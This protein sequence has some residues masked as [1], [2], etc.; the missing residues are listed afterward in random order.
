[1]K[2]KKEKIRYDGER[3]LLVLPYVAATSAAL[4]YTICRDHVWICTAVMSVFACAVYMLVYHF[5]KKPVGAAVLTLCMTALCFSA[6]LMTGTFYAENGFMDFLFTASSFFEPKFAAAAIVVFSVVIGFMCCYFSVIMPRICYLMLVSFIPL[7]LS[8]RTSG[9]TPVA[10]SA[11]MFGTFILAVLG[12]AKACPPD[13]VQVFGDK[14]G[15][16]SRA[17]AAVGLAAL[18]ALTAAVLPRSSKTPLGSY[19]DTVLLPGEGYYSG[20]ERLSNFVSHSSVNKGDNSTSENLLFTVRT[21]A[22]MLIDR[23]VFDVYNGENGWSCLEDYNTGYDAWEYTREKCCYARLSNDLRTAAEDGLLEEYAEYLKAVSVAEVDTQ[24]MFIRVMD[25]SSTRVIPHPLTVT[26]VSITD[27]SGGVYRTAKGELFTEQNIPSGEYLVTFQAEQ[28]PY[29]F[30]QAVSVMDYQ[31]LLTDA[32]ID[33]VLTSTEAGVFL[34]EYS[35]AHT[36]YR[37]TGTDGI[38][39]ELQELAEEITADC[40]TDL[41]KAFAIE[42]WFGEQGFVYDLEFVPERY[43]ADYFVFE[44]RTGI[45][46]D[47]ATAMTLLARA[48]GLPARYTEGF[49]LDDSMLDEYGTYNVTSANTHAYA[50]IYIA[51][52]GWLNFD[53]TKY[54]QAAEGSGL[55]TVQAL[56]IAAIFAAVLLL[57]VLAVIFRERIG[58]LAFSATYALRSKD[59]AVRAMAQRMRKMAASMDNRELHS[60]SLGE[61]ERII[62]QRLSMPEEAAQLRAAADELLYSDGTPSGADVKSLYRC[63]ADIRRKKRRMKR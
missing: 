8:S 51:G 36:Y 11:V 14:R 17:A 31:Q 58:W 6:V 62:S 41:E 33:G 30:A 3:P 15:E 48:A 44:S 37:K 60:L 7:I 54:V 47:Y 20:S 52:C 35:S 59:S 63:L 46:S 23:W 40:M 45:C 38:S 21:E 18:A 57:A 16:I 27:Y 13:G 61:A 1:M 43:E 39:D 42:R 28:P 50:Q 22:S 2:K 24:N 56:V 12:S 9:E 53:P 25:G 55:T 34:D 26:R 32:V 19:L 10:L 4:M 5:R 29:N 49:A